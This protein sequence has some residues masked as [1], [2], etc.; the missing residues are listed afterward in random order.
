MRARIVLPLAF[1][2]MLAVFPIFPGEVLAVF[3]VS[4]FPRVED[5]PYNADM[6]DPL[7]FFD[8]RSVES[9]ADWPAR[10]EELRRLY[11]Y[12]MYGVWPD[13]SREKVGWSIDGNT[14]NITV[15]KDEKQV[16][17]PVNFSL[18]DPDK[19]AM[20]ENG[21]PVIIAF[22]WFA[23]AQQ[24][25]ERGYAVIT[26]N[27]QP[28]AADNL[29]RAGVF[30]EL[31]PYGKT[32]EEQTGALMAWAWGVSKVIDALQCGAGAQ[33]NINPEHS[34]VAGVS[35]WGKAAAVAGAFDQRIKVTV[36]ACSGAGG[37][38][39]FRYVS[40]GRTYDYSAIGI[41]APYKM[42]QNEPLGSLQSSAERHWFNDNFSGFRHVNYL[43]F[44]QH[45]LAALCADPN[46]Y[47][48]ITGSY[49]YED[50]TNPP[51]MFFT[52]LAAKKVFDYL[53]VRDHIAVL[54][55]R[56]GHM[57]T[58]A[59][60]VYLLDFCDHHFYGKEPQMDLARLTQS[61]YLEPANLDPQFEPYLD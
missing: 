1:A 59:D 19:A 28:I 49:L 53:G 26:V 52:Y 46:R 43:P 24:A 57:I 36:P 17:F 13:A 45:L 23:Q 22:M 32:W 9:P 29:S 44:D 4:S 42:T 10:A 35:R 48:F 2:V 58:D 34:I 60:L 38:A 18:P 50:W 3:D 5:L 37:M 25:N 11:Q 15:A 21:Y 6:P 20:P 31:Y 55:H 7:T 39:A 41:A 8:G 40:E 12:Y 61:L 54:L 14:L 27:T 56:E 47:L 51:G 16:S 30:Y 33:L